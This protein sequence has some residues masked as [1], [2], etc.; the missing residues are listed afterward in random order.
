[1][2]R[3]STRQSIL[4]AT[5][6]LLLG[7]LAYAG[8]VYYTAPWIASALT[9]GWLVAAQVVLAIVPGLIWL[10][11]FYQQDRAE[12]EPKHYVLG[13]FLLG[14]VL[15]KL[16]ALPLVH[17]ILGV[18]AWIYSGRLGLIGGSV[19]VVGVVQ[20]FLKYAAVR[21]TVYN[22]REF[23]EPL[24]GI[25]Y[26]SAAGLG[27]ATMLNADYIIGYGGVDMR[28]GILW[29]VVN[30]LAHASF[31]A[32]LGYIMG[33]AKFR[34]GSDALPLIGGITLAA[35]LNGTFFLLQGEVTTRGLDYNPWNGLLLAAGMAILVFAV[36]FRL[37][38]RAR[39]VGE[40]TLEAE[41]GRYYLREDLPVL[42]AVLVLF[43]CGLAVRGTV[44]GEV[45]HVAAADAG[46][47]FELPAGWT[48]SDQRE[49]GIRASDPTSGS[50]FRTQLTVLREPL[51]DDPGTIMMGRALRLS[52]EHKLFRQLTTEQA[53][54]AGR[55]A[56]RIE[57]AY[58]ADPHENFMLAT[59][60]PVVV[61]A[62]EYLVVEGTDLISIRFAADNAIYP[63]EVKHLQRLLSSIQFEQRR[64]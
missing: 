54:I 35:V 3:Q 41:S 57:F 37:I 27:F 4:T 19:L 24:D 29:I 33:R 10:V 30:A 51:A 60:L 21:Y 5:G 39:Q 16:V 38:G 61:R 26:A 18:D 15:A 43:L 55:P 53:T 42:A 59:P 9:G 14:A 49:G 40:Q 45:Q 17:G 20:E 23:D 64:S 12:P 56:M 34:K 13:V 63:R 25:V 28:V 47:K 22:S 8:V 7:V 50:A 31:A 58:V 6:A 32:V 44:L 1:M 36:I 2:Q 46:L 52:N 48:M 11:V 62:E